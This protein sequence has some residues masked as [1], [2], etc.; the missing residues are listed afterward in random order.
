[1]AP[2]FKDLDKMQR[3]HIVRPVG[4]TVRLK[5]RAKGNPEPQVSWYKDSE[6]LRGEEDSKRRPNWILKLVRVQEAD[7]GHYTCVVFN[8]LGSL[9]YTYT[10]EVI[11]E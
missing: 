2:V 3:T 5:C 9:N 1:M 10:L 6:L 8:R 11:G 7:T 4:S